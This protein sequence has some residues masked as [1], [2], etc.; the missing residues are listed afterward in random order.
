LGWKKLDKYYGLSDDTFVY[1][2]AISPNPHL[3]I[4]WFERHWGCRPA[5]IDA[6]KDAIGNTYLVAKVRWPLD[7]QEAVT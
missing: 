6:A 5:W 4:A 1:R 3:I 2:I 7:A